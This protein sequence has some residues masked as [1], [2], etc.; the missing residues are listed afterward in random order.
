MRVCEKRGVC[1]KRKS[2]WKESG[3]Y[4]TEGPGDHPLCLAQ[5]MKKECVWKERSVFEKR[6]CVR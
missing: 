1:L 2:V 4:V 5:D 6:K 3:V